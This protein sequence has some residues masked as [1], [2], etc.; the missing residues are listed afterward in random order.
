MNI[1]GT[2]DP[3]F[4]R[5]KQVFAESFANGLEVGAATIDANPVI[6]LWEFRLTSPR[7]SPVPEGCEL[8]RPTWTK[9]ELKPCRGRPLVYEAS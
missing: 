5:V 2:C 6:D 1:K 9:T 7:A 4:K 8:D 3:R